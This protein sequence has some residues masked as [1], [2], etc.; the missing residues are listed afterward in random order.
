M[1]L[2]ELV[3][4]GGGKTERQEPEIP[5]PFLMPSIGQKGNFILN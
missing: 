1:I 2:V 3:N 4:L 5:L